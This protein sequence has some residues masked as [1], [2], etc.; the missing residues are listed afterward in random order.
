MDVVRHYNV[1]EL[2]LLRTDKGVLAQIENTHSTH[3][4]TDPKIAVACLADVIYLIGQKR[5]W[6]AWLI[7]EGRKLFRYRIE[8]GQAVLRTDP[9]PF[10]T[11]HQNGMD[12]IARNAHGIVGRM[13]EILTSPCLQ[14]DDTKTVIHVSHI[15]MTFSVIARS[16]VTAN[17]SLHIG[18]IETFYFLRLA[19][20]AVNAQVIVGN[21]DAAVGCHF[22]VGHVVCYQSVPYIQRL[23]LLR[24]HV[25]DTDTVALS[26]HPYRIVFGH[27]KQSIVFVPTDVRIVAV[28]NRKVFAVEFV[29][30]CLGSN[31]NASLP[32][33]CDI[34][35]IIVGQALLHPHP[36]QNQII[37]KCTYSHREARNQ[38]KERYKIA[39]F[40]HH[41]IKQIN[42]TQQK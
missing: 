25:K 36:F 18:R 6:T 27:G 20:V 1:A 4:G 42:C 2:H 21:P 33:L 17:Q 41:C 10:R 16:P 32:V 23:E 28:V 9:Y 3:I 34:H 15:E 8:Q 40:L 12:R 38:Y 7:T 5:I 35:H 13:A 24:V 14:I 37:L 29:Q 39:G 30:T 26:P 22:Q 11:V 31:P 19:I